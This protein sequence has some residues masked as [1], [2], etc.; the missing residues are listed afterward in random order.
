M[1]EGI[2][3]S[4]SDAMVSGI[5]GALANVF[6]YFTFKYGFHLPYENFWLR[7]IATLMCISVIFM[8]RLP[9]SFSP[10]FPYY[11]HT[12]LIF[13][14]PFIFTVNL[15][16]N[17]FHE[18][19]LYWEIFMI[20]VLMMFIPNWFMFMFDFLI[21]VLGAIIFYN[22]S[23]HN[24]PLD[25]SFNIPLYLIVIVFSIIAGYIFSFGNANTIKELERKKSE[26]KYLA[27]EALAGS[28]AHELRN[29][30]SQVHHNL[31]EILLELPV[32][33]TEK[34][35][36]S[37]P[38]KNI[39][40]IHKRVVQAQS[41][42]NRGLHVITMTL[43]NFRKPDIA[44][45]TLTCLSAA[46]V[47]RK[48]IEEY[49]YASDQEKKMITFEPGHDFIFLGEEDNY[50]LVLYNLLVNALQVLQA[51]PDGRIVISLKQGDTTNRV[52]VRDNGPGIQPEVLPRIFDSFFT[53][54][55][56]GGTGLGLAFCK[57]V[58]TSF[59]GTIACNSE[60]DRYTEFVL[61]F[62][63][64]DPKVIRNYES[65]LYEEYRPFFTGKKLLIACDKPEFRKTFKA[66]LAPLMLGTDTV[67]DGR[68]AFKKLSTERFD[69][70]LIDSELPYLN[71]DELSK[72][73]NIT[74]KELPVVTCVTSSRTTPLDY[75]LESES[76]LFTPLALHEV[77]KTLK[78]TIEAT[79]APIKESM[80]DKTVLVVDDQDFNRKLIKT[81][82]NKLGFRILEGANGLEAL[83]ILEKE[84]CDLL[85]MDMRMP[86]M[87]GFETAAQIRSGT[88][89]FRTI[90]ILGLS[91]N[92]DSESLKM[93]AE[94]GINDNLM[95]PVK[96]KPFLQKVTAMLNISQPA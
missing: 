50:T 12:F 65:Q 3:V 52:Y 33:T 71:T 68:E 55:K 16:M 54:G 29:P 45:S 47:T 9:K 46:T 70:V 15:L 26:E 35:T 69:L 19:W 61:E 63:A 23:T 25:P 58:M 1:K 95:K 36:E 53:S 27:L 66:L 91:G 2:F 30:L 48:A 83:K 85:I 7:L 90:P 76:T 73:L 80:S 93:A 67:T 40:T 82:L 37:L 38:N 6:F 44:K 75:N 21:G 89:A 64:V 32:K 57:R 74:S 51:K 81:M 24:I 41:A 92:V 87:D 8:H 42:V 72:K 31:N 84:H 39:E 5:I 56:K 43:G 96:L 79:R 88:T 4:R 34:E 78:N 17:N 13:V 10:Y 14:L 49:G 62:P 86:V 20:F 11:W 59:G 77:L 60:K 94:S 18:L 22:F 28:I